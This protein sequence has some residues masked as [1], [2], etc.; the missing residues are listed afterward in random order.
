MRRL[1]THKPR[2]PSKHPKGG[3]GQVYVALS[4]D[5]GSAI[6]HFVSWLM[7]WLGGSRCWTYT[8]PD[9]TQPPKW[10]YGARAYT[11]STQGC[12]PVAEMNFC[13]GF[14]AMSTCQDQVDR[15]GNSKVPHNQLNMVNYACQGRDAFLLWVAKPLMPLSQSGQTAIHELFH[16]DANWNKVAPSNGHVL[17]R[18]MRIAGPNGPMTVMAYGPEYTKVLAKWGGSNTGHLVATNGKPVC[19][20]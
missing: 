6:C 19:D 1:G 18:R 20:E 12:C 16:I 2:M 15:W 4:L 13:P 3:Q 8:Q 11:R 5:T 14:F 9:Q 17:D 7:L 10:K